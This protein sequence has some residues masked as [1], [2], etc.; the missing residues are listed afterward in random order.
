MTQNSIYEKK[1]KEELLRLTEQLNT[2]AIQAK[3][4]G[5]W[6]AIPDQEET[7]GGADANDQGDLIESWN[8]RHA[9]VAQLEVR[10]RNIVRALEKINAG[11][12]GTCEISGE[13]IEVSRLEANPAARTNIANREREGE[14]S[15]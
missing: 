3:D 7:V 13:T 8:E 2:I 4:T 10:Y 5:D 6:V 15:I 11:T 12:Y 14:L 9:I 1:L